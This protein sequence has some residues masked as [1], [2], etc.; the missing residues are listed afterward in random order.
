MLGAAR[1]CSTLFDDNK[2]YSESTDSMG[3][4]AGAHKT[5][6]MLDQMLDS[7]NQPE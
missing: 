4:N 5:L 1:C 6:E 7:F 2:K 3:H